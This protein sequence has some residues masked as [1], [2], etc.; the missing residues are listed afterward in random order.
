VGDDVRIDLPDVE[1]L[2]TGEALGFLYQGVPMKA[3]VACAQAVR[4][5]CQ[6][7]GDRSGIAALLPADR[8]EASNTSNAT[9]RAGVRAADQGKLWH[10][11]GMAIA[12]RLPNQ[13]IS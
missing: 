11:N 13:T 2:E 8:V 7:D 4:R 6:N 12:A 3:D 1:R 10:I 5:L 9:T